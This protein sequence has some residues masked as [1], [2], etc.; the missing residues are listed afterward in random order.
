MII[1]TG[2]DPSL[3]VNEGTG[4]LKAEIKPNSLIIDP[5]ELKKYNEIKKK[6]AQ[7]EYAKARRAISYEKGIEPEIFIAC[8]V[9]NIKEVSKKMDIYIATSVV[10]LLSKLTRKSDGLLVNKRGKA[11]TQVEIQQV[12]GLG[13]RRCRD[14]LKKI[15]DLK[16]I[17]SEKDPKDRRIILY[18]VDKKFHSMAESIHESFVQLNKNELNKMVENENLGNALG[19][20]YKILPYVHF[21]T[22]Y[23]VWNPTH[24]MLYKSQSLADSLL[25]EEN[26]S[27]LEHLLQKEIAEIIGVHETTI[28]EYINILEKNKIIKRDIQ[29]DSVLHMVHPRVLKRYDTHYVPDDQNE[30]AKFIEVQFKQHQQR[31]SNSGRKPNKK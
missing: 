28:N 16:V 23:L 3:L 26:P 18:Y 1:R 17:K 19:V 21:Q 4:E 14:V 31:K 11:I 29:G 27:K 24:N 9:N 2:K 7:K 22:F 6:Q 13:E 30:Y 15:V 5:D 25:D 8:K 20:L 10:K 12:L